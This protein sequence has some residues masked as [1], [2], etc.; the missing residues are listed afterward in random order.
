VA[1]N[2]IS[3]GGPGNNNIKVGDGGVK[4]RSQ[5]PEEDKENWEWM[6]EHRID[7]KTGKILPDPEG[8][9]V[10]VEHYGPEAARLRRILG[11]GGVGSGNTVGGLGQA[12]REAGEGWLRRW[13]WWIIT[14]FVAYL[15]VSRVLLGGD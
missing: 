14:G 15:V 7:P 10:G 13:K 1:G 8:E 5:W 12:A 6:Q 3:K 4:F 9:V 2:N 11:A